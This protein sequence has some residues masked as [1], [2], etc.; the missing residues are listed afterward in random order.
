MSKSKW[1]ESPK[2][3]ISYFVDNDIIINIQTFDDTMT[4][5]NGIWS[6]DPF[7]CHIYPM[8]AYICNKQVLSL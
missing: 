6:E 8:V 5:M 3:K 2:K 4:C 1:Q 7:L